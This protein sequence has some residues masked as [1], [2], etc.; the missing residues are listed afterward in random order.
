MRTL[1]L[2]AI[3]L[4][5]LASLA[6][7]QTKVENKW[8]CNAPADQKKLDAG[9]AAGHAYGVQQGTCN[10]TSSSIGEKSATYTENVEFWSTR[11]NNHGTLA[12]STDGPDKIFYAYSGTANVQDHKGSNKWKVVGG[13]G[14]YK[15]ATGEG[16]CTGTFNDKGSDWTCTGTLTTK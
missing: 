5:L 4:P 13:T 2:A 16:T 10:S 11:F 7:A 3:C 15:G 14:K 8:S 1:I 6:V 12:V 9:D